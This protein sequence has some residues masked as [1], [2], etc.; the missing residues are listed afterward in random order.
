MA[1]FTEAVVNL[2]QNTVGHTPGDRTFLFQ[3]HAT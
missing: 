2:Q 1:T 3:L